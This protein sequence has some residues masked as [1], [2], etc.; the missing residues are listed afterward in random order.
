MVMHTFYRGKEAAQQFSAFYTH[1]N[2]LG[3][4]NI[5]REKAPFHYIKKLILYSFDAYIIILFLDYIYN[6]YNIE[7]DGEAK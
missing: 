7:A 4:H 2:Y 6:K 5:P 3:Q 1:I